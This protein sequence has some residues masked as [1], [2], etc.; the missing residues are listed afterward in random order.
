[1]IHYMTENSE[2]EKL[3]DFLLFKYEWPRYF[4]GLMLGDVVKAIKA[5]QEEEN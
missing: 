1:M 2:I 4:N 5:Y 3:T